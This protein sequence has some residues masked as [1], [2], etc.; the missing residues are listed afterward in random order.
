MKNLLNSILFISVVFPYVVFSSPLSAGY[1]KPM[2]ISELE[3]N[4]KAFLKMQ[5][6]Y[7]FMQNALYSESLSVDLFRFMVRHKNKLNKMKAKIFSR[8]GKGTIRGKTLYFYR[9]FKNKNINLKLENIDVVNINA[10]FLNRKVLR[11]HSNLKIKRYMERVNIRQTGVSRNYRYTNRKKV[12][13]FVKSK[14]KFLTI[15]RK[16]KYYMKQYDINVLRLQN[17]PPKINKVIIYTR[18]QR[19]NIKQAK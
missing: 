10:V 19:I 9:D 11:N 12:D 7:D 13:D 2:S 4:P 6:D 18:N 16:Y 8:R 17:L 3:K 5:K 14:L 1:P 15:K